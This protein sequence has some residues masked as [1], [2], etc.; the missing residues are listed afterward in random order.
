LT[1]LPAIE[2]QLLA[3]FVD[4]RWQVPFGQLVCKRRKVP[5]DTRREL[6]E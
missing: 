5:D 6:R 4:D 3:R 2:L 1:A